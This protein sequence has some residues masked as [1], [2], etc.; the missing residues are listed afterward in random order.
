M[1][2]P[3]SLYSHPR[4]YDIGFS[5][6]DIATEVDVFEELIRHYSGV[7]VKRMLELA[8]G[9]SPHLTELARRGYGYTGIDINPAM[10]AYAREKAA[11]EGIDARLLVAN[12]IKGLGGGDA[13]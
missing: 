13:S 7:P 10:I 1:E 2:E 11:V 9:V 5:F 6:R 12:Y 8:S 4:Y 3:Y